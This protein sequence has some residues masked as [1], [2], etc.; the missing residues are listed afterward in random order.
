MS[1]AS[2]TGR[3]LTNAVMRRTFVGDMCTY[4]ATARARAGASAAGWL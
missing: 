3:P 1:S 2:A 4:F